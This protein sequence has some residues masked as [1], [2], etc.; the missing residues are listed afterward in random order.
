MKPY[1]INGPAVTIHSG[2]IGLTP[3][4]ADARLQTKSI[5]AVEGE[6]HVFEVQLPLQFKAGEI[7]GLDE[8]I[9]KALKAQLAE[10]SAKEL[11]VHSRDAEAQRQ[12]R[13]DTEE[14]QRRAREVQRDD[15]LVKRG[16]ATKQQTTAAARERQRLDDVK[17]APAQ[18]Q[19]VSTAHANPS[20]PG[21]P[22]AGGNH[23]NTSELDKR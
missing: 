20:P 22:T 8:E 21:T 9:G 7:V 13:I 16:L 5:V 2:R 4:Q 23:Q 19:N 12:R 15:Q 3:D 17:K 1:K 11:D 18:A 14:K 6:E 10:P